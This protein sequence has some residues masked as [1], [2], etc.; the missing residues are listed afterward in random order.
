[1]ALEEPHVLK[2]VGSTP[3]RIAEGLRIWMEKMIPGAAATLGL[4]P[5]T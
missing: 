3:G 1:M 5:E 4:C 2:E